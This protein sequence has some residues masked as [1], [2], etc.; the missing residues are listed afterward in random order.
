MQCSQT[1]NTKSIFQIHNYQLLIV[2]R[3]VVA[4]INNNELTGKN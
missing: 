2:N 4:S 3:P 1:M